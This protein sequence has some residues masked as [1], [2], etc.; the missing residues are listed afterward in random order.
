MNTSLQKNALTKAVMILNAL[1][2]PYAI[3]DGDQKLGTL[4][5]AE[6]KVDAPMATKKKSPPVH[7]HLAKHNYKNRMLAAKVGDELT[8]VCANDAEGESLRGAVSSW[9]GRAFGYGS[10]ITEYHREA[11]FTVHV[12]LVTKDGPGKTLK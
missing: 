7:D 4:E 2:L 11:D 9:C 6:P 3:M 8:F 1:K 10:T 5:I 12:L